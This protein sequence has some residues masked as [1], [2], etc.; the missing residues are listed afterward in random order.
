MV[1]FVVGDPVVPLA[2]VWGELVVLLVVGDPVVVEEEEAEE[3]LREERL[4]GD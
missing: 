4:D 1:P 3:L 2:L